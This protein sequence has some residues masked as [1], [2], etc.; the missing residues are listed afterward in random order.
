MP[1]SVSQ[2]LLSPHKKYRMCL[3]WQEEQETLYPFVTHSLYLS[4]TILS[5]LIIF[6]SRFFQPN[7]RPNMRNFSVHALYTPQKKNIQKQI[8][9]SHDPPPRMTLLIV[10][11]TTFST[12]NF[13]GNGSRI[14]L[15]LMNTHLEGELIR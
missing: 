15:S 11:P 4:N 10:N 2:Q 13:F 7:T 3:W 6:A 9:L 8:L 14:A 1:A 5:H 12:F